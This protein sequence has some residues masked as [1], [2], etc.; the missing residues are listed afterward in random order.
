[1]NSQDVFLLKI[2][3]AQSG[4]VLVIRSDDVDPVVAKS[5]KDHILKASGKD[6]SV[7]VLGK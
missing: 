2:S 6:I 1:M 7:L 4:D 3:E 5:I